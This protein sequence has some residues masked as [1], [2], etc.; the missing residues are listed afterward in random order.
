MNK[1]FLE[2]SKEVA[3]QMAMY[4]SAALDYRRGFSTFR[5]FSYFAYFVIFIDLLVTSS[6]LS[7]LFASNWQLFSKLEIFRLYNF[8]G[9]YIIL[10]VSILLFHALNF[11]RPKKSEEKMY[12][13]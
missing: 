11:S 2:T 9:Y 8:L 12:N 4:K 7:D 1:S 6:L 3:D 10:I 5:L 13:L